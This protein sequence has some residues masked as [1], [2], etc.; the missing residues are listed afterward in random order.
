QTITDAQTE[1]VVAFDVKGLITF[2]NPAAVRMLR[3]KDEDD[4]R[5]R[6]ISET[7]RLADGIQTL[8]LLAMLASGVVIE[9]GDASLEVGTSTGIEVA[10]SFTPLDDLENPSGAVLVMRDVTERRA[11][12]EA[13]TYRALH[14]ELTG[15]PNRR[16]FVDRL[17]H[18]L[19]RS[20][21]EGSRHGVIFLD[22]D[23]F[24]LVND[25]FGHLVGDQL[26]IQISERLQRLVTTSDTIARLSGDEFVVLIEDRADHVGL[27]RLGQTM[28]ESLRLPYQVDG[29]TIVNT[30]SI[31]VAL[32]HPGQT[33]DDVMIAADTAAYAAKSGGGDCIRIATQ[34]LV[35]ASRERS[36]MES[37]LRQAIEENH[38]TL[39]Y[40]PIVDIKTGQLA[41]LEALVRWEPPGSETV[42]PPDEFIPLAEDTGLVVT[43]GHWVLEEACRVTQE[44]NSANP[45]RDPITVS[46]NL[47]A[48]QLAQPTLVKDV[49]D[50]LRRTGLPA[51]HLCLEITETAIFAD[52]DA[53]LVMLHDLRATG[54]RLSVD[55]FGTGYSSLAYLRQLPVD[56][57]KLDASFIAGLGQDPV[58][59]QIVAAVLRLCKALGRRTV[60]EGVE[61]ELQRR[62]LAHMGCPAVQGYLVARPMRQHDF[63]AFWDTLYG[64]VL[65]IVQA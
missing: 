39:R 13:L 65:R 2:A 10:Y 47:S 24:K 37:R 41:G 28:L 35:D 48:L 49:L 12:Q 36:A 54:I 8:D 44:W 43:L 23:R 52:T 60:A 59:T 11:F 15:L 27:P 4:L 22:L 33:R 20:A 55:D 14:D 56:S 57:V 17:D 29:Q 63:E 34:A 32:T 25:S 42:I 62:T 3:A 18:A 50:V 45:D 7:A 26:L 9:D 53:N 16:L 1:G 6:P 5:G 46:V 40:Q 19:A 21:R 30:V 38:L 58:D 31:G 64:P 61:T 51:E